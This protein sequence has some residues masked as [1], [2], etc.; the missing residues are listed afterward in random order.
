MESFDGK[1]SEFNSRGKALE[2]Q[3]NLFKYR[4]SEHQGRKEF[5]PMV[6]ELLKK[7]KDE[8]PG[9][10][11]SKP[12]ITPEESKDAFDRIDETVA[13]LE[14]KVQEQT[15]RELTEE[16][17]FKSDDVEKRVKKVQETYKKV[18]SK[19]KPKEKKPKKTEKADKSDKNETNEE[20]D[21]QEKA[22]L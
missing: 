13:W 15:K 2:K 12:W 19:L 21:D 5:V 9:I 20:T 3:F 6:F 11:T 17:A 18:T 14:E 16:P 1:K 8:L 10:L 4:K 22:D 7:M